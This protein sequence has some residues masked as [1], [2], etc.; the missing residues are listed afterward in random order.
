MAK[1]RKDLA[2]PKPRSCRGA[3]P[4]TKAARRAARQQEADRAEGRRPVRA[5]LPVRPAS[6]HARPSGGRCCGSPA[7][8]RN[9]ATLRDADGGGLPAVRPAVPDGHGAGQAGASCGRRLRRF[10]RLGEVLK[11]L[12]VAGPGEG[13]GVP[14]RAAAGCDVERGGAGE[15]AVSQDAEDGVPGAD[16]SGRSRAGWR[17]TCSGS[18]RPEAG[19]RRPR[20]S[21]RRGRH[22]GLEPGSRAK[23]SN[24]Q[25]SCATAMPIPAPHL[26]NPGS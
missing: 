23:D 14:G 18:V 12:L 13:A 19:S 25:G 22:D 1:V 17:W 8:C 21:T 10:G 3:A 4:A 5:P 11:K 9:C 6:A 24:S 16:A 26:G 2:A 15:P 20:P 7:A